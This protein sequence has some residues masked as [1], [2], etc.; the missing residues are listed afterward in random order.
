MFKQEILTHNQYNV[1]QEKRNSEPWILVEV[2]PLHKWM[3]MLQQ[4]YW[5]KYCSNNFSF[6]AFFSRKIKGVSCFSFCI[7]PDPCKTCNYLYFS[8]FQGKRMPHRGDPVWGPRMG[9]WIP[10]TLVKLWN[11]GPKSL[12]KLMFAC[13]EQEYK[14]CC[15]TTKLACA[16]CAGHRPE[17]KNATKLAKS[18]HFWRFF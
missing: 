13:L 6:Y 17:K 18:Q 12:V 15:N 4:S 9:E 3:I 2:L 8:L 16:H 5:A 1:K 10:M 7:A 14:Q 11:R